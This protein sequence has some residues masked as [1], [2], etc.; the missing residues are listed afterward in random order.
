[1][2]AILLILGILAL[3][4][5]SIFVH[6]LGHFLAARSFGMI[7][8]VFSI[9][10]GKAVWKR[11]MFGTTVQLGWLPI[12]GY[13]ALPQMDPNSILESKA[14]EGSDDSTPS[15]NLPP[16]APW[17]KI[18][19]AVSGAVGNILFAFFLATIVWVVGKPASLQE[20]NSIVGYI[21]TNSPALAMGL[22]IGDE[23]TAINGEPVQNWQDILYSTA[24]EDPT[25]PVQ[26]QIRSPDGIEKEFSLQTE[27]TPLGIWMLPGIA[28]MDPCY[29]ASVLPGSCAE[30]AGF[31]IGDQI[32]T[33]NGQKLYARDQLIQLV[34]ASE[35]QLHP[36]EFL[37]E[38]E[39][40]STEVASAYNE[41]VNRYLMGITF[42][43]YAELD[44]SIRSHP[45]PWA[46]IKE[47]STAIFRL[48]DALTTPSTSGAAASAVGGPIMILVMLWIMLKTSWILAIFFT[49]FLNVNLAIINLLPLPVLDGGHVVMNCWEWVTGKPPSPR[50]VNALANIF[51]VILLGLILLL[52]F[53]DTVRFVWNPIRN[54]MTA[55]KVVEESPAAVL[56]PSSD[57]NLVSP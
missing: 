41:K 20:Q 13:V 27:K 10:M 24:L 56:P 57:T 50:L 11:K 30:A 43:N 42:D 38:G 28:G 39:M 53:R 19:V 7:A 37:R 31:R 52:V 22:T 44:F 34:N 18:I 54:R 46:Q 48:L 35:G 40:L 26:L 21:A 16:V 51:A 49:G 1:M 15:R 4:S 33:Y 14:G 5:L 36:V 32:I 45:T 2:I 47:H 8:D 9:G 55:A 12:G 6:E 3:F 29:V 23:I 25:Q 17:K